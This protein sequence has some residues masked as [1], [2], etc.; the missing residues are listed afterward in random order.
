VGHKTI[1]RRDLLKRGGSVA[2]AFALG[3]LPVAS[4]A[5]PRAVIAS[6]PQEPTVPMPQGSEALLEE[7]E[8]LAHNDS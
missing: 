6:Q 8:C 7:L 1:S 2:A 4:A 3:G 5:N